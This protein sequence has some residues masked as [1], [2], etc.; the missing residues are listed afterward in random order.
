MKN[1][2]K[3][4]TRKMAAK[5]SYNLRHCN[6]VCYVLFASVLSFGNCK[7][8]CTNFCVKSLVCYRIIEL[9]VDYWSIVSYNA[10][11]GRLYYPAAMISDI[12]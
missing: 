11:K 1:V 9:T 10:V 7:Y 8:A 5:A 12:S 3:S 4:F 2:C 6:P